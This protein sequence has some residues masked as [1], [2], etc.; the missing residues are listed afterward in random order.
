MPILLVKFPKEMSKK[1][2]MSRFLS[3]YEKID[4]SVAVNIQIND[5]EHVL[6]VLNRNDCEIIIAEEVEKQVIKPILPLIKNIRSGIVS[7]EKMGEY[8]EK[9]LE[10]YNRSNLNNEIVEILD[11]CEQFSQNPQI[12]FLNELQ[13]KVEAVINKN[14]LNVYSKFLTI[15]MDTFYML[16]QV[17]TMDSELED[18]NRF[19]R[20]KEI[21]QHIFRNHD[22]ILNSGIVPDWKDKVRVLFDRVSV[23]GGKLDP[24]DR[25]SFLKWKV[26]DLLRGRPTK[27]QLLRELK[28][29]PKK[30]DEIMEDLFNLRL[31]YLRKDRYNNR[32]LGDDFYNFIRSEIEK[33]FKLKNNKNISR[34][35]QNF[36]SLITQLTLIDL[37]VIL[38]RSKRTIKRISFHRTKINIKKYY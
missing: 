30:L 4:I 11:L 2:N 5:L 38:E 14:T 27:N 31:I 28:I 37:E 8:V 29:N 22:I 10:K 18:F 3:K 32:Q 33:R 19:N 9:I 7:P 25:D 34:E 21:F 6:E 35:C 24:N 15:D 13:P 23:R 16:F 20:F 36:I 17:S 12:D 26:L 1:V